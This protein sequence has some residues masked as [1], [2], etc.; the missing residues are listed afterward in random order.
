MDNRSN[1]DFGIYQIRNICNGK[2]YIGSAA[3]GI[4]KRWRLHR[5]ML[6]N[7]SHHSIYL[8]RSWNKYGESN[9]AFEVLELCPPEQCLER[10]QHYFSVLHPEYNI[11][12]TAGSPLGRKY[13]K[14]YKEKMREKNTGSGNPF[15]GKHHT[16]D[17]KNL[18]SGH[19]KGKLK[20]IMTGEKNP[21]YNKTHSEENKERMSQASKEFWDSEEGKLLKVKNALRLQGKPNLFAKSGTNHPN[22]NP[23]VY[24]FINDSGE[25]FTGTTYDFRKKYGLSSEVYYLANGKYKQYKGWRVTKNV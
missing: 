16:Q 5:R 18:M 11:D 21:M 12:P 4:K 2:L 7:N 1:A 25:M 19:L 14:E 9:F 15:F 23:T 6:K 10:E 20:G 3:S 17:S 8:Q 13:S 22:Y 24:Q